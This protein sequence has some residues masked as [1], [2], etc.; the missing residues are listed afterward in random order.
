MNK[1]VDISVVYGDKAM[2]IYIDSELRCITKKDPYIKAL[3]SEMIPTEFD[4]GFS[5]GLGCDKRTTMIIKNFSVTEYAENELREPEET[6]TKIPHPVHLT[7]VDKPTLLECIKGL[8]LDLQNEIIQTDNF[9]LKDLKK[10][11]GFKR[12]IEGGYPY[13]KISYVSVH[14]LAY[15]IQITGFTLRHQLNWIRYNTKREQEKY[16]LQKA[17]Y[18]NETLAKLSE[19]SLEFAEE[20]FYR[21]YDCAGCRKTCTWRVIYELDG[22]KKASCSDIFAGTHFK[23]FPSDFLD[24]R[25][26]VQ[27]ISGIVENKIT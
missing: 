4:D 17:D 23:M 7:V 21:I 11:M 18:T 6:V 3:K 24:L 25:K 9:L 22:K 5:I 8:E 14:G 15:K 20:I 13:S 2:W 12:K 26:V 10:L 19:E 27:A 1:F 16:G